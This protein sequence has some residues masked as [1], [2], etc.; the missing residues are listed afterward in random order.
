MEIKRRNS[1]IV[2][3]QAQIIKRKPNKNNI[4]KLE[5]AKAAICDF[6]NP[7]DKFLKHLRE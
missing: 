1:C 4:K 6:H 2:D 5:V 3:R 7:T